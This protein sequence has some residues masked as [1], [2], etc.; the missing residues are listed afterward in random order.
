MTSKSTRIGTT[1]SV[2]IHLK[3]NIEV[4]RSVAEQVPQLPTSDDWV[5]LRYNPNSGKWMNAKTFNSFQEAD[6]EFVK[7]CKNNGV[8]NA[9]KMTVGGKRKFGGD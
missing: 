9:N 4:S 3:K 2:E 8:G 5:L 7:M 6:K 1:G